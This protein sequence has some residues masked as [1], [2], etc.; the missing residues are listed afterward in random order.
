VPQLVLFDL[1]CLATWI[2]RRGDIWP[3]NRVNQ[4]ALELDVHVQG[5]LERLK[6]R[7]PGETYE[8][9]KAVVESHDYLVELLREESVATDRL[10]EI[11]CGPAGQAYKDRGRH[12]DGFGNATGRRKE[13]CRHRRLAGS[14]KRRVSG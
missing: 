3:T 9:V 8:M 13:R 7:A 6:E 10:L 12:G 1:Q 14:K 5:V 2:S 4:R 11:L